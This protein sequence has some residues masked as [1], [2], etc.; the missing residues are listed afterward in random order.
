LNQINLFDY[1]VFYGAK[2]ETGDIEFEPES[3]VTMNGSMHSNGAVYFGGAGNVYKSKKYKDSASD[4]GKITLGNFSDKV[5]VAGVM[6]VF[7]MRKATNL[8]FASSDGNDEPAVRLPFLVPK[9]GKQLK[10]TKHQS[11]M[12]GNDDLN[13][14]DGNPANEKVAINGNK[15]TYHRDSRVDWSLPENRID[16]FI[17]DGR[18]G[19]TMISTIAN[20]SDFASYPIEP[21][22][23]VGEQIIL[24]K[25]VSGDRYTINPT[26]VAAEPL[27]YD[28]NGI[29]TSDVLNGKR[30]VYAT[31]MPLFRFIDA[32]GKTYE[33]V[34]P[35]QPE[36]ATS[37]ALQPSGAWPNMLAPAGNG[38]PD[39]K[40]TYLPTL[41][42]PQ[43]AGPVM[44]Y[45]F[46][47]A[48]FGDV[49]GKTGLTIRERGYQNTAF[50]WQQNNDMAS[51]WT[52]VVTASIPQLEAH[53]VGL[54]GNRRYVEYRQGE[55]DDGEAD[56]QADRAPHCRLRHFPLYVASI[57][58][59]ALSRNRDGSLAPAA[60]RGLG[61][62]ADGFDLRLT[63][64]PDHPEH[65]AVRHV[66]VALHVH[67]LPT[68]AFHQRFDRGGELIP[69]DGG[70]VDVDGAL[71]IDRDD[72]SLGHLQRRGGCLRNGHLDASLQNRRGDHE[73]DEQGEGHVYEARD[74]D[75]RAYRKSPHAP[76]APTAPHPHHTRPSRASVPM[77]SAAKPSSS[78]VNRASFP[79]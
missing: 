44:G 63:Q 40:H 38:T 69:G 39:K 8:F 20:I 4:G 23:L 3:D 34:W 25:T 57:H 37:A 17:R 59:I 60:R 68:P 2:G 7:R 27:F 62:E 56:V 41:T 12:Q 75:L 77:N 72:D 33:D 71:S 28:E 1:A 30:P 66:R 42:K 58:A 79:A 21:Q 53:L 36:S 73:D 6:G 5:K 74:V 13:G 10:I 54:G 26:R 50:T 32:A 11:R 78:L 48:L 47:K 43:T 19:G 15:I 31:D 16:P 9:P 70:V 76:V 51:N 52:G 14:G 45:Y 22:R 64:R 46:E 67:G 49:S 35:N 24:Y 55:Q 18:S 61:N 29:V 65:R